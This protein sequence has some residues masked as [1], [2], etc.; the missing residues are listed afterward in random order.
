VT[1]KDIKDKKRHL[2]KDSSP[3][4][5]ND[6]K[7]D[8]SKFLT[9]AFT[10]AV[11]GILCRVLGVVFR[12][13]LVNIV[14]NF[15][16]GLYQMVFPLYALL[17]IISSAG[18]PVAIS[19]MIARKDA[20]RKRILFNALILLGVIGFVLSALFI[21]FAYQ[22][23][24]LQ[25]HK[26]AGIIYI[27]I[28]PSVF[29]VCLLSAFRGYFQGLQNM[30]PTAV[31]Q[32]IEQVVKMAVGITLALILFKVSVV[33][34]VFGAILAVT[35]SEVVALGYIVV[36]YFWKGKSKPQK[37]ISKFKFDRGIM[38]EIIKQSLPITAM[39]SIFPLILVFDSMVIINLLKSAGR[40]AE[41]ATKLFGIQS[42]TVHTLINLPAVI[43]VALAT[44]V[45]PAISALLKQDKQKE[46]RTH[47]ALAIKLAVLVSIFFVVFYL[48]FAD[49]MIDFLYRGAFRDNPAH[50]RV[51]VRLLKIEA[52]M[53]LL[54]GLSMVFSAMLQAA[55]RS[56]LPLISLAVG[57]TAKVIF[58]LI[59]IATPMGI[60]A[61]SIS[62]VICFAI[63]GVL[64]TVF[65]L[66]RFKIKGK[67]FR[68]AF[69]TAVLSV[70]FAAVLWALAAWIPHGRWWFLLVSVAG[71]LFYGFLVFILKLFDFSEQK[72]FNSIRGR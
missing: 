18:V 27:A 58:E 46:I 1:E 44:A 11:A 2:E 66:K 34:A 33:W 63:A 24:G 9:G 61:V 57:G 6:K 29:L 51:A 23:A 32:V 67:F 37:E 17:L 52:A 19:K 53:I 68:V 21:I 22:I 14:G 41:E 4:A 62:N 71:T 16:M 60:Y 26:S 69:K 35:I 48:F 40:S 10:L 38:W 55:D 5:Q 64:N 54:M 56:K 47:A 13:P 20:D 30:I 8:K 31:S 12:I 45:V 65:A 25:G 42:G 28:A 50:F 70:G 39:A 36:V 3:S 15:G 49:R 72:V 7:D 43:G 59:F